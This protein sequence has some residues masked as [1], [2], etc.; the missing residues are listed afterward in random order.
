MNEKEQHLDIREKLRNLPA[1]QASDDF[2]MKLQRRINL[3]E[4]QPST[5]I[6]KEHKEKLEGGFFAKLF[7]SGNNTWLVPAMG[8]TAVVFL[9]FI[10]TYVIN[11]NNDTASGDNQQ[12]SITQTEDETNTGE[13]ENKLRTPMGE[14][15]KTEVPGKEITE[16]FGFTDSRT[17]LDVRDTDRGTLTNVEEEYTGMRSKELPEV[18]ISQ[19]TTTITEEKEASPSPG[20]YKPDGKIGDDKMRTGTMP[21]KDKKDAK[22][23][24]ESKDETDSSFESGKRVTRNLIDQTD[25][26]N[27]QEKVEEGIK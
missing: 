10:W 6:H 2:V 26:E 9:V 27:L 24:V 21:S 19:P 3:A 1:V 22:K 12:Q 11:Q 23:K 17:E 20:I 16:S 5:Q 7:G 13:T 4:A 15:L 8:V 25:L 14:T 18:K